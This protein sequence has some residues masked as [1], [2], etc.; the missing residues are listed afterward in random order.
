MN[1]SVKAKI[2]LTVILLSVIG[3]SSFGYFT[4]QTYKKDKLAF[5]YDYLTT[6]TKAKSLLFTV[7]TEDHEMFLGSLISQMDLKDQNKSSVVKFLEGDQKKILGVYLNSAHAEVAQKTMFESRDPD[8]KKSW[9]WQDLLSAPTGL[10]LIDKENGFFL[11]KKSVGQDGAFA[12]MV[13]RQLDLWNVLR[14]TGNRFNFLM[15]QGKIIA[16][17]EI[18]LDHA[19]L[20]A[21]KP[22]VSDSPGNFGLF[23]SEIDGE[24][25]Y[26]TYSKLGANDL[27]LIN[28]IR[29]KNVMLVED[30]LLKQILSFLVL[31]VSISMLIGSLAARWLT[32]HL[33][34][35]THAAREMENENFDVQISVSSKDELGTLG[36]AFNKMNSRIKSLLETLRIYN[37]ELEEK[38]A[39]RTKELKSLSDIQNG[40][41]NALGQGFVIVDKNHEILPV[42][43]KVAEEM[44]EVKPDAVEP[45]AIM[46]VKEEDGKAFKEFFELC[47]NGAVSFEDVVKL[48]PDSRLNNKA[49][50]IQLDYAP[51]TNGE[52][53]DFEYIMI[54]GTDKT[55]EYENMEK[56]K[57]EWNFSQM[58]LKIA[59]N[60]FSFKKILSE[61]MNMLQRAQDYIK[62]EK[63][64]FLR[65]V[66]RQIHTIKGSL[67]YF[68]VTEI[69]NQCHDFETF[70]E[71]YYNE[72]T[73]SEDL[74]LVVLERIMQIQVAMEC[75]IEHFE[76]IIQFKEVDSKN[77]PTDDL[78]HFSQEL[79]RINPG[80]ETKFREKFFKTKV[81]PYFEMYPS[82]VAELAGKMGKDVRF[83][84]VGGDLEIPDGPWEEIFQQFIHFIRNSIDHGIERSSDRIAAGKASQGEITFEFQS[85]KVGTEPVLKINLKDDGQGVDW[86]KIAQ[87]DSNVKTLADALERI[88]MGGVSSRDEVSEISGRGVGVS[89]IFATVETMGGAAEIIS[90]AGKGIALQIILPFDVH[91]RRRG[92]VK[93]A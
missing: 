71:E 50:R 45:S 56:F 48:T 74:K 85:L 90:D 22:L 88:K 73:C 78:V 26:I 82:I 23:E 37:L 14:S 86:K 8:L 57:K 1:F 27:T 4:F 35:L 21:L 16:K 55:Q 51:I 75:Y 36:T 83:N 43:S 28:L 7:A 15:N 24:S 20:I 30:I 81:A 65:D 25:Y 39:A 64:F 34:A 32:W 61:S 87:K 63:D 60:R 53:Q 76:N 42:Y 59:S 70:L 6:E 58:I 84:L 10:S 47:F 41:L 46:G 11:L 91:S 38:V 44:F 80:L 9:S 31:M 52:S 66:Q 2:I 67:S 13:F 79:A 92:E 3:L 18:P 40:M 69:T 89:A 12:A 77:I 68:H 93:A 33:D 49:Q 62:E 19:H 72:K 17:N 54:V 5:V 29:T